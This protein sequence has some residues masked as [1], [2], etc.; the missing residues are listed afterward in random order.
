MTTGGVPLFTVSC[1]DNFSPSPSLTI[2]DEQHCVGVGDTPD[3]PPKPWL[4]ALNPC[5]F[6]DNALSVHVLDYTGEARES[7]FSVCV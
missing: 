6:A 5:S 1:A 3:V 7:L 2:N 4:A